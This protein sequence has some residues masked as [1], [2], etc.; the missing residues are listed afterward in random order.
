M[1]DFISRPTI[2]CELTLPTSRYFYLKVRIL[3]LTKNVNA[4]LLLTRDARR[5]RGLCCRPVSVRL[6]VHL[7]SVRLSRWCIV[8]IRLKLSSNF[9]F[10]WQPH[11]SSFLI[12]SADTQF[13]GEPFSGGAKYTGW[14]KIC[15]FRL[16]QP[17]I[18]VT[19][20]DRSMIAMEH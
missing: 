17:F 2:F 20:L 1:D 19:V 15:D 10:A 3:L 18:S 9:F 14:R 11:Q 8:S 12:F 5:K 4:Q 6:S 13:G 7:M 16:K